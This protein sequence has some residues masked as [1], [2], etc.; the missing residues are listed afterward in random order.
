MICSFILHL[1][2]FQYNSPQYSNPLENYFKWGVQSRHF[3][4]FRLVKRQK[5]IPMRDMMIATK[6][7]ISPKRV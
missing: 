1:L 6:A 3:L 4:T 2:L 5:V 7:N